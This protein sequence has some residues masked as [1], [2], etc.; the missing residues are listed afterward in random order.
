[1]FKILG[2]ILIFAGCTFAGAAKASSYKYRRRELENIIELLR[3]MQMDISY[4]K[5]SLYKTFKKTAALKDC[6]FAELLRICCSELADNATIETAW[7]IA[8]NDSMAACPLHKEDIDILH[9]ISLGIGK[10]DSQGQQNVLEPIQLRLAS[11][12]DEALM[13]EKKQGRMFRSLGASAGIIIVI[14]V[15]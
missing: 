9:D 4:R 11:A 1:M 8:V 15:L 7:S 13:M 3:F 10:S 6:W 2:C 5:D 14:L 12:L